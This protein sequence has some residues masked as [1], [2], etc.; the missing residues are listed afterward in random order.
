M[1]YLSEKHKQLSESQQSGL[2][3]YQPKTADYSSFVNGALLAIV[4]AILM[5]F[6]FRGKK[7][8]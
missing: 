6:I 3:M 2:M 4:I 8:K 1:N 5:V 7:S